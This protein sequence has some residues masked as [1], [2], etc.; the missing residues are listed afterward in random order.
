LGCKFEEDL[1]SIIE[2]PEVG[3]GDR[4][5]YSRFAYLVASTMWI[6]RKQT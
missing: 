6:K 5:N 4:R 1:V 2:G 3:A